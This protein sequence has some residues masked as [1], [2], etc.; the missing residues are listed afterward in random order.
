MKENNLEHIKTISTRFGI[1]SFYENDDPIGLSLTQYGE[2][3]AIELDFIQNFI[4]IG[5]SVLDVGANIGTHT[6]AFSN[7]VG[8]KGKVYSFEPQPAI[9]NLLSSNISI[10][11]ITNVQLFNYALGNSQREIYV[12]II[13]YSEHINSGSVSLKTQ[14]E[15]DRKKNYYSV[16][17]KT[18]DSLDI[19]S[20]DF[21]K[22]DV[23]GMETSV[24]E[25][26]KNSI[27]EFNP[28]IYTECNSIE[29]G[30]NII[31]FLRDFDY[32]SFY[33]ECYAYN[34][35]NYFNNNDNIF[36]YACESNLFFIHKTK[37]CQFKEL[38]E[39]NH[40]LFMVRS[41]DDLAK[42]FAETP[43]YGDKTNY[44]RKVSVLKEKLECISTEILNKDQQINEKDQ[45]IKELEAKLQQELLFMDQKIREKDQ[46]INELENKLTQ[47]KFRADELQYELDQKKLNLKAKIQKLAS[48]NLLKFKR[49]AYNVLF[50]PKIR[51]LLSNSPLFDK[52]YYERTYPDVVNTGMDPLNHFIFYGGYE[53]RDPSEGFDTSFY[54]INNSD[55][56][57]HYY[58]PLYHYIRFGKKEGREIKPINIISYEIAKMPKA[59]SDQ[60]WNELIQANLHNLPKKKLVDI[61]V[62]VYKGYDE[63]LACIYSVLKSQINIG[64]ELIVINDASPDKKLSNKLVELSEKG[65]FTLLINERNLGFVGTVNKG[66]DLH[67]DRDVL[68][69]NSDTIVYNDWLDRIYSTA[70]K[71]E[72]IGTVTPLSNNATICSY[73]KFLEDNNMKLEVDYEELDR[74]TARANSDNVIELPTAV[75]F[76]MYIK[77]ECIN[78]V[79]L[80]DEENFGKGYG[81]ENDFCMRALKNGWK[82]VL[83]ANVF[84]RHVGGA[85]FGDE[86]LPRIEKALKILNNKHPEYESLVK[87][88]IMKDPVYLVRRN[89]DVERLRKWNGM[90]NILFVTHNLG[91]GTERHINEMTYFLENEG[92]GVYILRPDSENPK[93]AILS[94]KNVQHI[95]NLKDLDIQSAPE[96]L[97][98]L[99]RKIGIQHIHIHH[100]A[101]FDS[102]WI[103]IFQLISEDMKIPYDFTIH[104]YMPICPRINLIDHSNRY[105]GEPSE[106]ICEICIKVNGSPFGKVSVREWRNR[107]EQLLSNA[108]NVFVPNQDVKNRMLNYIKNVNYVVKP[109]QEIFR[110]SEFAFSLEKSHEIYAS[111]KIRV[112]IIGAIGIHKGSQL[113]LECAKD[114]IKRNLPIE[115]III[116]YTNFDHEFKDIPNV[117]ITG[118][119]SDEE[120]FEIIRGFQ[121]NLA[122]FPAVCPETYSYTLSLA[123]LSGLFPVS[124]DFGAIA[125]RIKS[126]NWG[127]VMPLE[128]MSSAPKCNDFIMKLNQ[129][130]PGHDLIKQAFS[131]YSSITKEYYGISFS[132]K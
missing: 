125:E 3:A 95:Y 52:N 70:Y 36:G 130:P 118:K 61:I 82:N 92:I 112:A 103:E 91:G 131:N 39:N 42:Y 121:C 77:R 55:V 57:N 47:E 104:D 20:I 68:L 122:W 13:D 46:R 114:A 44:D 66:F 41:L 6:L 63:T 31:T 22:I 10:N 56:N 127:A 72:R 97:S 109:H 17:L 89:L 126:I 53:G 79:G 60:Q 37:F 32:I 11:S 120:F 75:G 18:I 45:Q 7:M 48:K 119:Y 90:F 29:N 28:F 102:Q 116:G 67:L 65:L 87:E 38:I 124:F 59:P 8:E 64:Y 26:S 100:L 33:H 25:G 9:F 54:L 58:N 71:N 1:L 12:P 2:W 105:C 15:N 108:R 51:K 27:L 49:R 99:L 24:L 128:Y 84:V 62:P 111:D 80:F 16:P 50:Y 129:F 88:F 5:D 98:D 35:S 83:S 85:S 94:T 19:P 14:V 30:W 110:T 40:R 101:G 117:T 69:L 73:P 132:N 74:M 123:L 76:C 78:D 93:K 4:K 96:S 106:K 107:Y 43:R 34:D 113:I 23:E 86:K 115:F 81:E 21:I